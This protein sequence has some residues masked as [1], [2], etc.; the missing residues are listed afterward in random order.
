MRRTTA[1][2]VGND[3]E[4]ATPLHWAALGGRLRNL[5]FLVS[6]GGNLHA[7]DKRGYN[8]LLH[9]A[10]QGHL[11]NVHYALQRGVPLDWY[12]RR[13]V[14]VVCACLAGVR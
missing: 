12:E 13:V 7:V 9:A 11:L 8:S 4:G 10:Q 2:D 3:T 5:H 14:C 6:S 1:I